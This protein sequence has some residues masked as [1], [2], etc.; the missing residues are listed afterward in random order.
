MPETEKKKKRREEEENIHLQA[1]WQMLHDDRSISLLPIS[2]TDIT[3][4]PYDDTVT[5]ILPHYSL[6]SCSS[7]FFA[8]N[9]L[10]SLITH[11]FLDMKTHALLPVKTEEKQ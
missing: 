5:S 6:L 9:M 1:V 3:H 10:L 2:I 7:L 4:S 11:F 8:F